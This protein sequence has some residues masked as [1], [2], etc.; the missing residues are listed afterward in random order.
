MN[1][2]ILHAGLHATLMGRDRPVLVAFTSPSTGNDAF[3]LP[4][5]VGF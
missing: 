1:R 3:S 2:A 5:A 4:A